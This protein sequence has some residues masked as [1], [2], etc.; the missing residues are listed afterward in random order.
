[1]EEI[2]E[3]SIN[4]MVR[5]LTPKTV[6]MKGKNAQQEVVTLIDCRATHNFIPTKL[7][8][9]L[10]LP[11]ETTS[12]YGVLMGTSLTIRGEGVCKSIP[13]ILQ[14][15]EI[16]E[17]FLPLDLGNADVILGMQWLE[18]IGGTQGD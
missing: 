16:V 13:L 15:I 6:K 1:M 4:S 12:A 5:M 2:V 18:S 8:Q 10:G 14:N 7:I 17:D 11:V 3:L 9:K